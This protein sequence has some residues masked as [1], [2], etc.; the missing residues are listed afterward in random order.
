MAALRGRPSTNCFFLLGNGRRL[1]MAPSH[2]LTVAYGPLHQTSLCSTC[3]H[4][5]RL[6]EAD[7]HPVVIR[8]KSLFRCLVKE[9]ED[10]EWLGTSKKS[11][12]GQNEEHLLIIILYTTVYLGD[13][14]FAFHSETMTRDTISWSN[15]WNRNSISQSDFSDGGEAPKARSRHSVYRI[16]AQVIYVSA[17]FSQSTVIHFLCICMQVYMYVFKDFGIESKWQEAKVAS[18]GSALYDTLLGTYSAQWCS[19]RERGSWS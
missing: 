9:N 4:A 11:N 8:R 5:S 16:L 1:M 14:S 6:S 7:K 17:R 19:Q 13:K 12:I 2:Q 15:T 18:Y 3:L 10:E